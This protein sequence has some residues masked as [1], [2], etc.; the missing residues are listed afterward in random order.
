MVLGV[1]VL[2]LINGDVDFPSVDQIVHSRF[3]GMHHNTRNGLGTAVGADAPTALFQALY[4]RAAL[5]VAVV[6]RVTRHRDSG[7]AVVLHVGFMLMMMM[8]TA[9]H[10]DARV[11][12]MVWV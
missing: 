10:G 4:T 6:S 11:L 7:D 2:L 8:P 3:I 5:F 12:G 9:G 1:A